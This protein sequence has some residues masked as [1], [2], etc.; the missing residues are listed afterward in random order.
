MPLGNLCFI[1]S[2]VWVLASRA[3]WK[4]EKIAEKAISSD[5]HFF[6]EK[7]WFLVLH[8]GHLTGRTGGGGGRGFNVALGELLKK[9]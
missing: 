7:K 2:G 9:L 3:A 6:P 8:P 1:K 5:Y 4:M